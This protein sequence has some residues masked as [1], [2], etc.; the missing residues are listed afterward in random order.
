MARRWI[1]APSTET[2]SERVFSHANRVVDDHR[3]SL[4][5]STVSNMVFCARNLKFVREQVNVLKPLPRTGAT[6]ARGK[7]N[8]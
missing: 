4:D 5:S 3:T 1:G 7:D 2:E 6:V 8:S